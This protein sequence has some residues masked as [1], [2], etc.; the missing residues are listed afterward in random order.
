MKDLLTL[1]WHGISVVLGGFALMAFG[2]FDIE[3]GHELGNTTALTLLYVGA[4]AII[5]PG[6]YVA[7]QTSQGN[8]K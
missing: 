6:V 7:G 1:P 4:S 8:G 2:V 3:W 5:G